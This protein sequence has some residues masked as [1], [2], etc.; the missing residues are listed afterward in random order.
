MDRRKVGKE[1]EMAAKELLK[2]R[3]YIILAENYRCPAGEIDLIA[4]D[5]SVLVFAEVKYRS[6]TRQGLPEEAVG[7]EKQ[8][9]ISRA[10][11]WYMMQEKISL[12]TACRFDVIS[13]LGNKIRIY[14]NAFD[15]QG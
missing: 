12:E 1:Y 11:R 3:G 10:A 4:A 2:E 15:F 13:I 9:R 14:K 6:G 7:K 8:R 5:G